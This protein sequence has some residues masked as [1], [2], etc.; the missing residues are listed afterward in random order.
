MNI[1]FFNTLRII[2]SKN[3][4]PRTF[5]SLYK[6]FGNSSECLK[7]LQKDAKYSSGIAKEEEIEKEIKATEKFGAHII[8][9]QDSRFPALLKTIIDCPPVLTIKGNIDILQKP[10][11]AIVGSRNCSMNAISFAY[12]IAANLAERDILTVSG[13]ARGIDTAVHKGSLTGGT[14]AA[15]AGGIDKIYPA[16]N[17]NLYEQ[18]LTEGAVITEMPFSNE[19]VAQN[20]PRR[21]RLIS[22]MSHALIVVE[23]TLNS[24]SLITADFALEQ[25]RDVYAVPSFPSDARSRG[26]IKLLKQGAHIFE[27]ID[28]LDLHFLT[29]DVK[30]YRRDQLEAE[31]PI[32]NNEQKIA[33]S[34]NNVD[35][36]LSLLS[37]VAVE[38]DKIVELSAIETGEVVRLLTKLELEGVATRVEGNKICLIDK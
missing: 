4:G 14:I 30:H 23:A 12:K 2:R 21:N 20:F 16:E 13:L 24:G 18:I 6:K 37:P 25:G 15:I 33:S 26:T 34:E 36:I 5:W 22:G 11:I 10:S 32:D 35:I 17:K 9:F 38:I 8:S 27:N 31:N 7:F 19:P 29:G 28:D 3:I 1:E